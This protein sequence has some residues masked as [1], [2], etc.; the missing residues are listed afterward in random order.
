MFWKNKATATATAKK[1]YNLLEKIVKEPDKKIGK[2][3]KHIS[4]LHIYNDKP[5]FA[6][7]TVAYINM[8]KLIKHGPI[9]YGNNNERFVD[10]RRE[11]NRKEL[12]AYYKKCLIALINNA[13]PKDLNDIYDKEESPLINIIKTCDEKLLIEFLTGH[14][15][16]VNKL[17][18][19]GQSP[20][21]EAKKCGFVFGMKLLK[22]YG[23]I[24]SPED[25]KYLESKMNNPNSTQ[26]NT[27][28]DN[29]NEVSKT[30]PQ[31]SKNNTKENSQATT[32]T[33][34]IG[35][36]PGNSV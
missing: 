33:F 17:D 34:T 1:L 11:Q 24:L 8:E 12:K 36:A 19:K 10:D 23:A 18:I 3:L 32:T 29:N 16:D 15:I 7:F 22:T 20:F 35:T 9:E 26:S 28:I 14:G 31:E 21:T 25:E 2:Y 5:I 27:T 30:S 13:A 4:I 6:H